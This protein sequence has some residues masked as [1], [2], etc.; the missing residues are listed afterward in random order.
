MSK[1][2]DEIVRVTTRTLKELKEK[3]IKELIEMALSKGLISKFLVSGQ[4]LIA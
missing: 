2:K 1:A 3:T 4:H